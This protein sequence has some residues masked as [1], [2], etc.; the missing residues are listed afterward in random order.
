MWQNYK[1]LQKTTKF[2]K[3]NPNKA[4]NKPIL[5]IKLLINCRN[6]KIFELTD[7]AIP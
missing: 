1:P 3:I 6:I 5:F 7:P 4:I 2:T